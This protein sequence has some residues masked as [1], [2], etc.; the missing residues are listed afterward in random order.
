M[1]GVEVSQSGRAAEV[2]IALPSDDALDGRPGVA[3]SGR[4]GNP[5]DRNA[6][7]MTQG[8]GMLRVRQP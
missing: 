6:Q 3:G 8:Q 2:F 1:L 4:V 7:Q 5:G